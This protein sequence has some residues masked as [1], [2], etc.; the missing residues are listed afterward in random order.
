MKHE[1]INKDPFCEVSL[2]P[3]KHEDRATD[4]NM[5][6][7]MGPDGEWTPMPGTGAVHSRG[8]SLVPNRTVYDLAQSAIDASGVE[9]VPLSYGGKG[10]MS[11]DGR[12]FASRWYTLAEQ[13]AVGSSRMAF[14]LE[15]VNSYDGSASVGA[16]FFAM[17]MLCANQFRSTNLMGSMMMKHFCDSSGSL[18][19]GLDGLVGGIHNGMKQFLSLMPAMNELC[20]H[21]FSLSGFLDLRHHMVE[22]GWQS[23][24]DSDMLDALS[25]TG[26]FEDTEV[27][28]IDRNVA[29]NSAWRVLNAYTAVCTHA[30]PDFTGARMSE[31]VTDTMFQHCHN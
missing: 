13:T 27:I 20:A 24:R 7:L 23:S 21:T 19:L 31:I 9:F 2:V 17:N 28:G 15:V 12:R 26:K 8:Y 30:M 1:M 11:W 18:Q 5:V 3:V 25:G 4:N 14:G 29:Q 16:R 10:P 6:C 22:A